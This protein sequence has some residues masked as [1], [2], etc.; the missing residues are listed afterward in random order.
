MEPG[1]FADHGYG[2]VMQSIWAEGVP[3]WGFLGVLTL[4]GVRQI[5][6][7]VARCTVCGFLECYAKE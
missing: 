7:T 2:N 6:V 1:F 5:K 3:R 4:R